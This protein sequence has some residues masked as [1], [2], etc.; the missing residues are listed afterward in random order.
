MNSEISYERLRVGRRI[1]GIRRTIVEYWEFGADK[2]QFEPVEH[3]ST[4]RIKQ[5]PLGIERL[6]RPLIRKKKKG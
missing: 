2:W 1:V 4:E 5:P 6:K 3:T